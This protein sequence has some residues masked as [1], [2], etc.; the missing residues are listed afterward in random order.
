MYIEDGHLH[1]QVVQ[2]LEH[3][4]GCRLQSCLFHQ[5]LPGLVHP[6]LQH[7]ADHLETQRRVQ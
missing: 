6:A 3:D 1:E 5:N 2:Q 7:V 4:P